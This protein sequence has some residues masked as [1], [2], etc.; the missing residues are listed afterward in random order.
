MI[1]CGE[2]KYRILENAWDYLRNNIK[3]YVVVDI[4]AG[5]VLE[6]LKVLLTIV[7]RF[8]PERYSEGVLEDLSPLLVLALMLHNPLAHNAFGAFGTSLLVDGKDKGL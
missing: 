5:W 6:G 2:K 4:L 3:N 1:F 7:V 8:V